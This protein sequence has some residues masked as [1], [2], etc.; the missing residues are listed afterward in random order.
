MIK[1]DSS[2]LI[3]CLSFLAVFTLVSPAFAA[4][5]DGVI[6]ADDGYGVKGEIMV[7]DDQDNK[8]IGTGAVGGH[9]ADHPDWVATWYVGWDDKN[10]YYGIESGDGDVTTASGGAPGEVVET[11]KDDSFEFH[12]NTG[13]GEGDQAGGPCVC[14]HQSS[15]QVLLSV[16]GGFNDT[17]GNG[18]G[19]IGKQQWDFGWDANLEAAVNVPAGTTINDSDDLDEGWSGE[20]SFP[21]ADM[22]LADG[23]L[24]GRTMGFNVTGMNYDEHG[25]DLGRQRIVLSWSNP[26]GKVGEDTGI[27]ILTIHQNDRWGEITFLATSVE[28]ADKLATTWAS[29]KSQ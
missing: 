10:I 15:Y 21:L 3:K 5:V 13:L 29:V 4:T 7:N 16:T 23:A 6:T 11:W 2:T 27:H 22:G 1:Y 20:M 8:G 26:V 19:E 25:G 18:S 14:R 17:Q 28:P 24:D 12:L 9:R